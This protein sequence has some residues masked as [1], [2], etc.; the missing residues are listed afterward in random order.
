MGLDG[1]LEIFVESGTETGFDVAAQGLADFGLLARYTE[2]HG[3]NY[4][5]RAG[6]GCPIEDVG[7]RPC[8]IKHC[9]IL[10]VP[11]SESQD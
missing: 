3:S 8:P 4:P 2:L 1:C 11:P 6:F 9:T 7:M 5:L 10:L